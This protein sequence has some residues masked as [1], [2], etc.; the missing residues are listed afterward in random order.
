MTIRTRSSPRRSTP[1]PRPSPTARRRSAT[2]S[3]RSEGK[4]T[5]PEPKDDPLSKLT[6]RL[7]KLEAKGNRPNGTGETKGEPST[8]QKAFATYLRQGDR[9]PEAELKVLTVSSDTQ[10]GYLAPTEMSGRVHP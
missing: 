5:T 3:P 7:D 6:E 1:S 9:A 2:V 8:E 10:G 4:G